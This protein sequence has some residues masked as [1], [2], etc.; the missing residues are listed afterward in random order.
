MKTAL[1][2]TA[3]NC[4]FCWYRPKNRAELDVLEKRY[5]D[6]TFGNELI[7]QWICVEDDGCGSSWVS[8]LSDSIAYA[9]SMLNKLGYKSIVGS[10]PAVW[11]IK[12]EWAS[13]YGADITT[14]SDVMLYAD[15]KDARVAFEK[16]VADELERLPEDYKIV[17]DSNSFE[18]YVEGNY[19]SNH[20]VIRLKKL[21]VF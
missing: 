12:T 8:L 1:R 19:P 5:T 4:Y 18:T 21:P 11:S 17:R 14:G 20:S 3:Q 2:L 9:Q 10:K 16:A 7:D 15:E 13:D 6:Q